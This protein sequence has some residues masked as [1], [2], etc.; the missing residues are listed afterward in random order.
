MD[1]TTKASTLNF[2]SSLLEYMD[3]SD[4]N[5][6]LTVLD[7]IGNPWCRATAG[8]PQLAPHCNVACHIAGV[9]HCV[10]V[11]TSKVQLRS[12]I[13]PLSCDF[14]VENLYSGTIS[15][16]TV[17][18]VKSVA[19]SVAEARRALHTLEVLHESVGDEGTSLAVLQ[20]ERP[21]LRHL[22]QHADRQSMAW[23]VAAAAGGG[24]AGSGSA[25]GEGQLDTLHAWVA[26]PRH[27]RGVAVTNMQR[28]VQERGRALQEATEVGVRGF[29]MT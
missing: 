10:R 1:L 8:S 20:A 26:L 22:M 14:V 19:S 2:T 23:A 5:T 21:H 7:T 29:F 13:W 3:P 25:D 15:S 28:R 4:S 17:H 12:R 11:R 16:T 27:D 18:D 9:T 24:V 6:T